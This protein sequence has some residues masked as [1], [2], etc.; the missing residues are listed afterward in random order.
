MWVDQIGSPSLSLETEASWNINLK[1][2]MKYFTAEMRIWNINR[3]EVKHKG[4]KELQFPKRSNWTWNA[5]FD[6]TTRRLKSD[7]SPPITRPH[8]VVCPLWYYK[9]DWRTSNIRITKPTKS[10]ATWST[11]FSPEVRST[12]FF[13]ISN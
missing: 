1:S 12:M 11:H 2:E 6:A 10:C 7:P 3:F 4:R 5:D 9:V 8:V 13:K